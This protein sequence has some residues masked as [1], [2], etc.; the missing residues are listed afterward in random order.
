M[1]LGWIMRTF[2]IRIDGMLL[3]FLLSFCAITI[4]GLI[5]QQAL[6]IAECLVACKNVSQIN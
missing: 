6:N 4:H 2:S 5:F 1:Y 3:I